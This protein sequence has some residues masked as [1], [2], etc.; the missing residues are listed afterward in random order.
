MLSTVLPIRA[1]DVARP[2]L[3]ARRTN[4][5][6]AEALGTVLTERVLD[7]FSILGIFL[8][9][10][11]LRWNAFPNGTGVVHGGAIGC[12]IVLVAL[13]RLSHRPLLLQRRRATAA[14]TDRPHPAEAFP[15]AVDEVLRRLREDA[16]HHRAAARLSHRHLR[17]RRRSGSAS[18]RS[19]G[20][21]SSPCIARLPYD[22]TLLHQ[23]RDHD[24]RR[25]PD[26]GRRRRL[27]QALSVGADVV[28]RIRHRQLRCHRADAASGRHGAGR[29]S[30]AWRSS[31]AKVCAGATSGMRPTMWRATR[32]SQS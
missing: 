6:F 23:R 14:R 12:T 10:C 32:T 24:R 17:H 29:R 9:F 8:F 15:R 2:A 27:P 11:V 26:A 20:S 7:L 16:G 5:R 1:G 25:H 30:P 4:V 22:S 21:S 13:D 28:L 18:P 19:T 31:R 3:L